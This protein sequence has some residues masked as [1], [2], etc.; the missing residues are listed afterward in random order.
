MQ[1]TVYIH[2]KPVF[3]TDR[4]D[5]QLEQ[6]HHQPDTI[7][8]D[9]LDVHTVKAMLHE[10]SLPQIQRGIFLHD[11]FEAL[12]TKFFKKFDLHVAGGG[13]VI[14]EL[15]AFLLIFRRGSWDLPKGHQDKGE[16]IET[17]ALREVTEETGLHQIKIKEPLTTTYHTYEQGTHHILKASHWFLMEGSSTDKLVP[18]TEEDIEA[19]Q[20]VAP[21]ELDAYLPKCYPSIRQV[22][23]AYQTRAK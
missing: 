10:I 3:L 11:D 22:I 13:L 23:H 21:S 8:I 1:I 14:N 5:Q 16:T 17:T 2:N 6:W 12:K 4:L 19:I 7:F 18:Q 15:G 9:E 20:W